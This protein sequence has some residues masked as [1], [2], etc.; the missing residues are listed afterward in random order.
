MSDNN[1]WEN[2]WITYWWVD[3]HYIVFYV[4]SCPDY[5]PCSLKWKLS[6]MSPHLFL[7]AF[8]LLKFNFIQRHSYDLK[9]KNESRRKLCHED[10][11]RIYFWHFNFPIVTWLFSLSMCVSLAFLPYACLILSL[12]SSLF[13]AFYFWPPRFLNHH[14]TICG[15]F[16]TNVFCT[17]VSGP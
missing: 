1:I 15:C 13:Y 8:S 5:I 12:Y 16:Q 7:V 9:N 2:K 10:R 6:H 14:F 4:I 3:V 11:G 17:Y